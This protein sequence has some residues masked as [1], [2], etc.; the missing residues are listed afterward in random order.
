MAAA[1]RTPL[2]YIRALPE[3]RRSEIKT[4][5]A[6]IRKTAPGLKPRFVG[7]T[8]QWMKNGVVAYGETSYVRSDGKKVEWYVLGLAGNRGSI[9]LYTSVVVDGRYLTAMFKDALPKAVVGGSYIRF[10]S[11]ADVDLRVLTK[12]IREA[13]RRSR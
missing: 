7:S 10:K 3:P 5:H 4:L 12:V 6:L 11:L 13:A 2:E 8:I 1:P 9:S